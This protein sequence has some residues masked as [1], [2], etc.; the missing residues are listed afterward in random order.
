MVA[1]RSAVPDGHRRLAVSVDRRKKV[2]KPL[3]PERW[4]QDLERYRRNLSSAM[5]KVYAKLDRIHPT[6]WK[7]DA[8]VSLKLTMAE[9]RAI[10]LFA[11]QHLNE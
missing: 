2:K 5:D 9:L 11:R 6:N 10:Q 1:D 4:K 3:M 8:P 7:D